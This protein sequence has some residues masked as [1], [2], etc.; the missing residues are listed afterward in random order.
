MTEVDSIIE[1]N[2]VQ[3]QIVDHLLAGKSINEICIA[4][5]RRRKIIASQVSLIK[6]KYG[7]RTMIELGFMLGKTQNSNC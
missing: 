6:K 7:A 3:Q 2:P 4:L 5:N 1:L